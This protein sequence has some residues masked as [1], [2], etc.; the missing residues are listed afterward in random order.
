M[1]TILNC[2]SCRSG[3]YG[4]FCTDNTDTGVP[5]VV[6]Q[7]VTDAPEVVTDVPDD[8]TDLY[9][10]STYDVTV[11]PIN[12]TDISDTTSYYGSTDVTDIPIHQGI[13][14]SINFSGDH[15]DDFSHDTGS[16]DYV[17]DESDGSDD[18]K[19]TWIIVGASC[20][21]SVLL[22]IICSTVF[23]YACGGSRQKIFVKR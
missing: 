11:V 14:D 22:A 7:V 18:T 3:W 19:T 16:D 4:E 2:N 20:V 15:Q 13:T 1:C 5:D 21:A 17:I 10:S 6:T 23:C 8:Q 12:V 9:S